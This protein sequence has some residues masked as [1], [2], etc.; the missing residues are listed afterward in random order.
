[1]FTTHLKHSNAYIC[2][3]RPGHEK[4]IECDLIYIDIKKEQ[5]IN[6]NN[7]QIDIKHTVQYTCTGWSQYTCTARSQTQI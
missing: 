6:K 1:M 7:I 3:Q 4:Y 2:K 5:N